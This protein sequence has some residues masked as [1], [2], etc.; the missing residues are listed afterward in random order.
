MRKR[1]IVAIE[2]DTRQRMKELASQQRTIKIKATRI[3]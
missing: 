3:S 2:F 1:S